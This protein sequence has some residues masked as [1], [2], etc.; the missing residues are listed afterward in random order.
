MLSQ[1]ISKH[2]PEGHKDFIG[3]HV[4][5]M[6]DEL[7]A[8]KFDITLRQSSALNRIESQSFCCPLSQ[9][10]KLVVDISKVATNAMCLKMFFIFF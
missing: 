1:E 2:L 9:A 8:T 4:P 6:L 5:M 7:S 3:F 10:T